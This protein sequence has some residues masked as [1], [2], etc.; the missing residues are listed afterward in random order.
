MKIN[1]KRD[2][3]TMATVD[4]DSAEIVMYGDVVESVPTNYWSGEPVPGNYIILDEFLADLDQIKSCKNIL[5]RM[6]SCGGDAGVSITIH[7]RLRELSRTGTK[8]TCIVDGVAMSGGSLIASAADHV[9][10]YASS[11]YMIHLCMAGAFGWYNANDLRS[12]AASNDAYDKAQVSIYVR[13]TGMEAGELLAMMGE[14][15]YM[16]GREAVE[17]GF[18]DELLDDEEATVVSA[19]AD[20]K[21]LVVH[22]RII[23]LASGIA[24][25]E[26][27]PTVA[28]GKDATPA[29]DVNNKLPEMSG[30]GGNKM[31]LEELRQQHPELVSEI[32]ASVSHDA[33]VSAE[34]Q[35]VQAI[36][37]IAGLF[38]DELVQEAKYG[39]NPCTAQELAYRAAQLAV[40]KGSDFLADMKADSDASGV[41]AVGA[42]PTSAGGDAPKT[43]EQKKAAA[44][45][46]VKAALGKE[47]K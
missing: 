16:T 41:D 24:I 35:R 46:S 21:S 45:A 25:P 22:G 6:N 28:T 1:V 8:I 33:A 4:E 15:T 27:I 7:N 43:E 10:V 44:R 26:S 11:L 36:D 13:K 17:K 9:Q 2:F 20:R 37:Q 38:S 30:E 39:E 34:R 5:I 40:K 31:T 14:T 32:E 3:Y 23:R 12:L 19:S 29:P 47:E 42:A 18:A